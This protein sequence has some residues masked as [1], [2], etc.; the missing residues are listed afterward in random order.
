MIKSI[1]NTGVIYCSI[2]KYS[3][4]KAIYSAKALKK[5]N[6]NIPI[7][8]LTYMHDCDNVFDRVITTKSKL[9]PRQQKVHYII[10]LPYYY[11]LYL[12]TDAKILFNFKNTFQLLKMWDVLIAAFGNIEDI[13]LIASE[14][15]FSNSNYIRLNTGVKVY[16]KSNEFI[17]L[18]QLW[19]EGIGKKNRNAFIGY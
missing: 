17:E 12:I 18:C 9:N 3:V 8:L 6:S 4:S 13:R 14:K 15:P 5:G 7:A 19:S 11:S 16:R 1:R 2:V 10:N